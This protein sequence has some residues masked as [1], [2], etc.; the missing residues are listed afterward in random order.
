M[1]KPFDSIYVR[2]QPSEIHGVGV[3]AIK[4]IPSNY[5]IFKSTCTYI[6]TSLNGLKNLSEAEKSYY[7]DFFVRE[8]ESIY[9]PSIHPQ[10]LDI[11]FFMNHDSI[12][13][14]VKYDFDLDSFVT[15]TDIKP[16]TE[17]VYDYSSVEDEIIL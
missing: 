15:L 14:N 1:Q 9:L 11:S 6:K 4:D 8:D 3:F 17:L 5:T 13:P 2:I 12:N 7:K 16:G 10:N